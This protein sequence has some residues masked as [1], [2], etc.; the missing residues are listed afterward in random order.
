MGIGMGG[1]EPCLP[2]CLPAWAAAGEHLQAAAGG[3]GLQRPLHKSHHEVL[4][5][6]LV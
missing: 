1:G 4:H 3:E 6:L 5:V 2:A